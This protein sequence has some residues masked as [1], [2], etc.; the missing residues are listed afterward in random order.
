[1]KKENGQNH[2]CSLVGVAKKSWFLTNWD[3]VKPYILTHAQE[4]PDFY[5]TAFNHFLTFFFLMAND[6]YIVAR[7]GIVLFQGCGNV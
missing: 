7:A 3:N 5:I 1:M 6:N 4:R 2:P